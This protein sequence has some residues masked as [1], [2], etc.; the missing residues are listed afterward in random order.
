[1]KKQDNYLCING[2]KI[3][4]TEEQLKQI[5]IVKEPIATLSDDGKI[6]KIGEY[7]FIV[8]KNDGNE[9]HLLLKDT[10]EDRKFDS[11][12]N[13]FAKSDIRKYLDDFADKLAELVGEENIVKH[14]VDLTADDGLKCYGSCECRVSLLTAQMYREHV[15]TI[16]E[17]KISKWWWL[18]TAFSTPKHNDSEWVKGVSPVGDVNGD[19]YYGN[20]YGVRPFCILKSNIFVSK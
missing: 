4:L 7:K 18:A 12:C 13:N 15:Y 14:T 1:M 17:F 20:Y 3:E 5:G 8:L 11:D 9:V 19:Y 6:A 10:L 16:D 2:K